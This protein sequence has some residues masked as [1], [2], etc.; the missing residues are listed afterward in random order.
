MRQLST[1]LMPVGFE[2]LGAE[3]LRDLITYLTTAPIENK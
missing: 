3:P 1:S 2:A